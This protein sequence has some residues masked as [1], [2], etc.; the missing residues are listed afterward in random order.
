MIPSHTEILEDLGAGKTL[1]G[2]SDAE[3]PKYR[4]EIPRVGGLDPNWEML[5]SLK[6]DIILADVYHGRYKP[7][8]ERLKLPV[9]FLRSTKAATFEDIYSVVADIGRETDRRSEAEA[10]VQKM[11][12]RLEKLRARVPPGPGPK[13][14]F[15]I[16]PQPVRAC[17]PGSLQGFLLEQAGARNIVPPSPEDIPMMSLERVPQQAPD[18]ILHTGVVTGDEIKNRPGWASVP[19]VRNGRVYAVD[20]DLFSRAGPRILDAFETLLDI[21]YGKNDE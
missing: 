1:V 2:V 13:I 5:V 10:L 9:V 7:T 12:A 19:A 14:C 18:V 21:L 15:E 6:P 4:P 11:K 20:R 8:F 3:D 16:W 17:S